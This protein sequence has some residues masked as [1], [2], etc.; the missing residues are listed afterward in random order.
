[1]NKEKLEHGIRILEEL[2]NLEK[3]QNFTDSICGTVHFEILKHYGQCEEYEKIVIPRKY[4]GMLFEV[5]ETI[6]YKLEKEIENL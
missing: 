2:K 5:I 1:M 6:V 4:N 3:Y